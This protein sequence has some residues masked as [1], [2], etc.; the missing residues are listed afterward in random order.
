MRLS[1]EQKTLRLRKPLETAHGTVRERELVAVTLADEEGPTGYGEAAPL[2][3]YDGV[4]VER[5]EDALERYR[6]VLASADGLTGVQIA[7]SVPARGRSA[8][9][10]GGDRHG[11][12]GSRGQAR[13]KPVAELLTDE[14]R[15]R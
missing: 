1:I 14:P 10:A 13:G 9:G 15:A 12:V 6:R 4:S 5:V 7:G 8:P 3:Q 11:A 2:E